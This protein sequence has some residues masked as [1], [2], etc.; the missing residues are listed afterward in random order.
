MNAAIQARIEKTLNIKVSYPEGIMTKKE[1]IKLKFNNGCFVKQVEKSKSN[2]N[3]TK[4]NRMNTAE[5][6]EY[7]KRLN[8]KVTCYEIHSNES[9]SFYDI[10]KFEFDYFNS[11]KN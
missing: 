9:S 11:L 2:F 3:R 6:E 4:F 5:Q 10:T 1:W 8:T 7:E